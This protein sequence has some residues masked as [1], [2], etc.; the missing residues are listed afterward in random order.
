MTFTFEEIEQTALKIGLSKSIIKALIDN[1]PNKRSSQQNKSLHL[2]FTNISFELNIM[3]LEFTYRGIKGK[4][5]QTIYT[6][7]IVKDYLWR[8]LQMALIGKES[9]TK[10]NHSDIEAI[11][12]VLGKWFSEQGVVIEFPSIETLINKTKK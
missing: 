2:L 4:E 1:L 12:M 9:T 11:F 7:L 6:P 5:I 3:G 10:L 8:P